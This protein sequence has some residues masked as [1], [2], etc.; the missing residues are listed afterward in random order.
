M[1]YAAV[2]NYLPSLAFEQSG[3]NV[4]YEMIFRSASRA[5]IRAGRVRVLGALHE[6]FCD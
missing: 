4:T 5:Q 6:P 1:D 2:A 3:C